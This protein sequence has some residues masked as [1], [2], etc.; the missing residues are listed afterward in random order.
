MA[1]PKKKKKRRG[2]E[3]DAIN[4]DELLAEAN[5][6]AKWIG[7]RADE[8]A[9]ALEEGIGMTSALRVIERARRLSVLFFSLDEWLSAGGVLPQRW[10]ERDLDRTLN[11]AR[12]RLKSSIGRR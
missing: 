10:R 5:Q 3:L 11:P 1:T 8:I 12:A 4:L 9:V 7:G 6:I 2:G